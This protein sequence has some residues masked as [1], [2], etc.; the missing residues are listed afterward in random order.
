MGRF[1]D[2]S[3]GSSYGIERQGADPHRLVTGV[4]GGTAACGRP[5]RTPEDW[6][7]ASRVR[8]KNFAGRVGER[9]IG[10]QPVR[11]LDAYFEG[12]RLRPNSARTILV[13]I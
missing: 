1:A 4:T 3:D 12:S 8:S 6:S 10:D 2:K 9:W 13:G 7:R 5:C 11:G